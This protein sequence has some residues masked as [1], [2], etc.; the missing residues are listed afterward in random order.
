M[1][2]YPH[3]GYLFVKICEIENFNFRIAFSSK[4]LLG[5]MRSNS[6]AQL[7]LVTLG[8]CGRSEFFHVR[9]GKE[10]SNTAQP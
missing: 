10:D 7:I 9:H 4:I 2:N 6:A 8:M 3:V 1:V 5:N